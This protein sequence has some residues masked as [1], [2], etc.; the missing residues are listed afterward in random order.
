MTFDTWLAFRGAA[1]IIFPSNS[2]STDAF[3]VARLDARSGDNGFSGNH[4]E[5]CRFVEAVAYMESWPYALPE[6]VTFHLPKQHEPVQHARWFTIY[7][8]QLISEPN[9]L[10]R[11]Q[12]L[13]GLYMH[14]RS[15]SLGRVVRAHETVADLLIPM[16]KGGKAVRSLSRLSILLPVRLA[17]FSASY[18]TSSPVLPL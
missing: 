3:E 4:H 8:Y 6:T 11:P 16:V 5:L 1:K 17:F 7:G 12:F 10:S 14:C 18:N 15:C 9:M 13:Q 2:E